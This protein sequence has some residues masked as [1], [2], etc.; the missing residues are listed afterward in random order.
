MR[1]DGPASAG[2]Y[3]AVIGGFGIVVQAAEPVI[4][5]RPMYVDRALGDLPLI[6]GGTSAAGRPG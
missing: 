6:E 4:V 1:V 5:E 3:G 2:G